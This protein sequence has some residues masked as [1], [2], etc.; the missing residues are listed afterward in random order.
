MR[1]AALV[2]LPLDASWTVARWRGAPIRLHWTFPALLAAEALISGSALSLAYLACM[3]AHEVGHGVAARR[4]GG[5]VLAIDL[6]PVLGLCHLEGGL[7]PL[8]RSLVALAGPGVNLAL[9]AAAQALLSLGPGLLPRQLQ[10]GASA[11]AVINLVF[12]PLNLLPVRPLDGAEGWRLPLR[13][14]RHRVSRRRAA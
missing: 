13:W 4:L 11:V 5:D 3:L 1:Y 6:W 2:R 8:S 14:W 7:P 10:T 9:F 12:L